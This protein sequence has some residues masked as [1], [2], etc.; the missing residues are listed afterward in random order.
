MNPIVLY[1][2]DASQANFFRKTA[3]SKGV[4]VMM[5]TKEYAEIIEDIMFAKSIDEG[6][7][8][9]VVSEEEFFKALGKCK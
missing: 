8:S 6:L 3:E 9:P 7:K 2:K 4:K 5:F 1:P